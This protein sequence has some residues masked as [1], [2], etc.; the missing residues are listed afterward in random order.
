M[1]SKYPEFYADIKPITVQDP[2][3][4]E[5]GVSA[6]GAMDY[7]FYD[8]AK[9]A[10][11]TCPA[12]AGAFLL[13]KV[14]LRA[15]YGEDLPQRGQIKI[16]LGGERSDGFSGAVANVISLITGATAE[17][18]FGGIFGR[19]CRM[20]LLEFK[21]DLPP[22]TAIFTRT[23]SNKSVKVSYSP[24]PAL[25]SFEGALRLNELKGLMASSA[26]SKEERAEFARLW[27]EQVR[28]VFAKDLG[29]LVSLE[30]F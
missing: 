17:C 26:A 2:L 25:A 30:S 10:G 3:A 24:R 18:G 27:Q 13:C 15:L 29:D 5:L 9:T 12:T 19:N 1:N 20:Q 16:S 21:S 22:F 6:D 4:I 11:H 23:D 8:V 14:A 7:S 28:L